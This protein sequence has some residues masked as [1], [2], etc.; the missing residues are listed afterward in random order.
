MLN[1]RG[2]GGG[3]GETRTLFGFGNNNCALPR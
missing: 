2:G 1:Q 3:G